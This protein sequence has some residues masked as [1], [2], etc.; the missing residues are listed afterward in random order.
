MNSP[1]AACDKPLDARSAPAFTRF[2]VSGN[3]QSTSLNAR[4]KEIRVLQRF[5]RSAAIARLERVRFRVTLNFELPQRLPLRQRSGP[6]NLLNQIR[7][8]GVAR[9]PFDGARQFFRQQ[10]VRL[11]ADDFCV[12]RSVGTLDS[13]R[14]R[15]YFRASLVGSPPG[16]SF[17]TRTPLAGF[18]IFCGNA[19]K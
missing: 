10:G 18:N 8:L 2:P 6:C 15:A 14:R 19:K 4:K 9:C 13:L 3:P 11:L 17:S 1:D 7:D 12:F 16:I 5:E